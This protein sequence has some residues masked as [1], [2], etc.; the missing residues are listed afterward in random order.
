MNWFQTLYLFVLL[1]TTSL[2][3]KSAQPEIDR[4]PP[5]RYYLGAVEVVEHNTFQQTIPASVFQ[6]TDA[7]GNLMHVGQFRLIQ[8]LNSDP[9]IAYQPIE[10]TL[11]LKEIKLKNNVQAAREWVE[12]W[13]G[14]VGTKLADVVFHPNNLLTY[15]GSWMGIAL[16]TGALIGHVGKPV[17]TEIFVAKDVAVL[18]LSFFAADRF[19]QHNKLDASPFFN[20]AFFMGILAGIRRFNTG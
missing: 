4:N 20:T 10:G 9:T 5:K 19:H 6:Q 15:G 2:L 7:S 18:F 14:A 1:S 16:A 12:A 13:G 17:Y 11:A 3:L 8:E